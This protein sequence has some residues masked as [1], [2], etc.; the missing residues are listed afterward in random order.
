MA[1]PSSDDLESFRAFEQSGWNTNAT[2]YDQ[3]FGAITPFFCDPLLDGA[4]VK[5]GL[6]VLDIATGPGYVAGA[7]ANRGADAIGIDFAPNMVAEARKLNPKAAFQEGDAE[8]L[9][10]PD[11][12]FDAV[13]ISFGML[14]FSRPEAVLAEV[15]RVLRPG[16]SLAFTVWGKPQEG[17]AGFGILL[18]AIETHGTMDVGLPPGPPLFRFSD[19]NEARKALLDAG[20]VD[21]LITD[22]PHTWE[23]SSYDVLIDSF[24]EAGVRA[25]ELLRSQNQEALDRIVGFVRD[26]LKSYDREGI[27]GVPMGAVLASANK[28]T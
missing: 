23:L 25:G 21:P 15:L 12:S 8:D 11:E 10:F 22:L 26:E 16:G 19:H 27:I 24:R 1:T 17:A 7:A 13:V 2:K 3:F 6:R 28:P 18:R 20:F 9:S 14:H 5:A 4:G